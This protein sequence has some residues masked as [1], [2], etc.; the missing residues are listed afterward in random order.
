[1]LHLMLLEEYAGRDFG[2]LGLVYF[3]LVDCVYGYMRCSQG[4]S[5]L[6]FKLYSG[7]TVCRGA[8]L[9]SSSV[10]MFVEPGVIQSEPGHDDI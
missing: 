5:V 8:V 4:G 6:H 7:Y 1:M 3:F 10:G 9:L 2:C